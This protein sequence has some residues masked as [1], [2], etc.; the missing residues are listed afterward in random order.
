VHLCKLQMLAAVDG[1]IV[2]AEHSACRSR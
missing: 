1:L 2:E